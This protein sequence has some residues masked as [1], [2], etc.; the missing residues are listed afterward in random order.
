[1]RRQRPFPKRR[2]C[3]EGLEP[4]LPLAAVADAFEEDDSWATAKSVSIDGT[5]QT[6]SID[7]AGEMDW[8]KFQLSGSARVT[9]E[10]NGSGGDTRIWL[11]GPNDATREIDYDD[12][13]GNGNFSRIDRSLEA[14]TYYVLIDEYGRNGTIDHYTL[15]V[16]AALLLPDALETDNTASQ[17]RSIVPDGA[18]QTHSLHVPD[19]V[20]WV[21]FT[22]TT[23]RQIDLQTAGT[24]GDTML[25]L[26]G[27]N[28]SSRELARNDDGGIGSFSRITMTLEPG[29]YYAKVAEYGQNDVIHAYT[30]SLDTYAIPDLQVMVASA[31]PSES[32][33][34]GSAITVH[35]TVENRGP[36]VADPQHDGSP[37]W[38]DRIYL[39][40]DDRL[41]NDVELSSWTYYG[42]SL[43][44]GARY[45]GLREVRF[46]SDIRWA[47]S[48]A[49]VLVQT[50]Y[51]DEVVETSAANNVRAIPIRFAPHIELQSPVFDQ[52]VDGR[53]PIE[54][55]WLAVDSIAGSVV[56]IALDDDANPENGVRQWIVS[57]RGVDQ[58]GL[59]ESVSTVLAGLTARSD[60]YYVW[61]RLR[62]P[63]TAS[64][65]YS[66]PIPVNAADLAAFSA[67]ALD[68]T[69]GGSSYE[70]FGVEAA[71][72][73][74]SILFRVRTNFDADSTSAGDLF[75]R[76]GDRQYGLALHTHTVDNG[77]R[78]VAGNLYVGAEFLGGTRHPEVPAFIRSYSDVISGRSSIGV[79]ETSGNP[80]SHE[81]VG[82]FDVSA[83]TGLEPGDSIEIGWSMYCGNDT[84]EVE[85]QPDYQV[86]V[87]QLIAAQDLA[88]SD[89]PNVIWAETE[90]GVYRSVADTLGTSVVAGAASFHL[91]PTLEFGETGR[92]TAV[93]TWYE[94]A[95]RGTGL[96]GTGVMSGTTGDIAVTGPST[97]G[98]FTLDVTFTFTDAAGQS[99]AA[100]QS[101]THELFVLYSTPLTGMPKT[102]QWIERAAQW[103]AV[104]LASPTAHGVLRS[105]MENI[106]NRSGWSYMAQPDHDPAIQGRL[107]V[108]GNATSGNCYSFAEA[109]KALAQTH[110]IT[111]DLA[112]IGFPGS[113]TEKFLSTR[114]LNM[115]TSHKPGNARPETSQLD[116][117]WVFS[118][119]RVGS[120]QGWYFD[121]MFNAAW[122]GDI[123]R[124]VATTVSRSGWTIWLY[125]IYESADD[126]CRIERESSGDGVNLPEYKYT[127]KLNEPRDT[128]GDGRVSPLDALLVI[129]WLNG[130]S[131][132]GIVSDDLDVNQD[133]HVSPLDVLLVID[134]LNGSRAEG[135]APPLTQAATV[136]PIDRYFAWYAL[137]QDDEDEQP[138][139]Y[140]LLP[141]R[142]R[143]IWSRS[144]AVAL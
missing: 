13:D 111:V 143:S 30:I 2:P 4:R 85:I 119:H 96:T 94:W 46:P 12:D 54:V 32:L 17:A 49:Y 103:G 45:D 91:R 58:S 36:G 40:A 16:Q 133:G 8:A 38:T 98:T 23:Q 64:A 127:L 27:P 43:A 55:R 108:E 110:G 9:I 67:D 48:S 118:S 120:Y 56:D 76:V 105:L 10:T 50:D 122:Q 15:T 35:W 65:T 130:E 114:G 142:A 116:D 123:N 22:L 25:W 33:A 144:A 124:F 140:A 74:Q 97:T 131:P 100:S 37:Q 129:T 101:M 28:D 135:E 112:T 70:V 63:G 41:G 11:Y 57:G 138:W 102:E 95:I 104:E 78:V 39:S 77:A 106:Y 3:F 83:I 26:Y 19:D 80:W 113:D 132:A 44:A 47:G 24:A 89:V 42:T 1:M 92:G 139:S 90:P 87:V 53:T 117:R 71:Q 99:V 61:A 20:D 31:E 136:D 75:L 60:P 125:P 5:V 29:T 51:Y 68:D 121:P 79:V 66:R 73:G 81:I 126:N 115:I 128:N 141:L 52:F 82:S 134:Y 7:A 6:R 93:Q 18:S 34:V 107:L 84:D 69:D 109:W 14:G 62:R 59:A 72:R 88:M 21:K 86:R 137:E